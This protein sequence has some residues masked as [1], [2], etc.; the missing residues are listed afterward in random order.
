MAKGT[1]AFQF[2]PA[3][4]VADA[5]VQLMNCEQ[6]GAY[7]LLCCHMWMEGGVLPNNDAIL[8]RLSRTEKRWPKVKQ[9]VMSCFV[10]C[11]TK[12]YHKRLRREKSK[13]VQLR[14]T[15][16]AAGKLGAKARWGAD[17]KRHSL[18]LAKNGPSPSSSPSTP[19]KKP[20]AP[21]PV[22]PSGDH[23]TAIAYFVEA[24][25]KTVS[26]PY[27]F[28]AGKDGK[29]VKDLLA[30]FNLDGF[31]TMVDRYFGDPDQFSKDN[32]FSLQ[33]MRGKA[34]TLMSAGAIEEEIKYPS[35]D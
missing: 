6:I 29:I 34:N 11:K 30:T 31:K 33:L 15:R 12:V 4:F 7:W 28:S 3:D 9:L 24:Y 17:G 14:K 19:K 26:L 23:A 27:A 32:G 10:V 21:P 5:R 1:P 25:E 35:I 8:A 22:K 20:A 2:Y 18:P 13:Q 16:A